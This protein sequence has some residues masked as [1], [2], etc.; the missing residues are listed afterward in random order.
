VAGFGKN[1]VVQN[2]AAHRDSDTI[3]DRGNFKV[4]IAAVPR[5]LA[6]HV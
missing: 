6:D 5:L 4:R 1:A 3:D 2:R